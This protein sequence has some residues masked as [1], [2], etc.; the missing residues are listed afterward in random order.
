MP[1]EKQENG[2]TIKYKIRFK[3][4]ARFMADS[5]STLTDNLAEGLHK[6]KCKVC[7]SSLEQVAAKDG[8]LTFKC[9]Y[10]NK[11]Y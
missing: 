7:K 3:D 8:L 9:A 4:N 5:L 11:T 10:R 1:I 2:K 6:G